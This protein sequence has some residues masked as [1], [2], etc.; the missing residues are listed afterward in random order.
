MISVQTT[1]SGHDFGIDEMKKERN[2]LK[3]I[4]AQATKMQWKTHLPCDKSTNFH[5][6][7]CLFRNIDNITVT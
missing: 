4:H 3:N 6:H 2:C 5:F 7:K 1:Q